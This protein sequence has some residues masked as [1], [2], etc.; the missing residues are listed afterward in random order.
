MLPVSLSKKQG[1]TEANIISSITSNPPYIRTRKIHGLQLIGTIQL[2]VN[3]RIFDHNYQEYHENQTNPMTSNKGGS[4][5]ISEVDKKENISEHVNLPPCPY[6]FPIKHTN[7][8]SVPLISSYSVS[9]LEF[10]DCT[11]E[12]ISSTDE[13][14]S[15]N[16]PPS[17]FLPSHNTTDFSQLRVSPELSPSGFVKLPPLTT[18]SSSP[19]VITP[20]TFSTLSALSLTSSNCSN[21]LNPILFSSPPYTS[22][23]SHYS[24]LSLSPWIN[25]PN[26]SV[27]IPSSNNIN[28]SSPSKIPESIPY[29]G[30][31]EFISSKVD[32]NGGDKG[33]MRKPYSKFYSEIMGLPM[34]PQVLARCALIL[35][36]YIWIILLLLFVL[37]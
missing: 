16:L 27:L 13:F 12:S 3:D 6:L 1:N 8:S 11:R 35:C 32:N 36:E 18:C 23:S 7:I 21:H 37:K 34:E 4:E 33:I 14:S 30:G 28:V 2:G 20:S 10:V 15:P 31:A 9:P 5:D 26:S 25:F 29:L 19:S 22:T 24:P 17:Y